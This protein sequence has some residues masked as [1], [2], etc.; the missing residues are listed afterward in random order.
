MG[1]R[2]FVFNGKEKLRCGGL[3]FL[4]GERIMKKQ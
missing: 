3:F 2:P 1:G 4:Q